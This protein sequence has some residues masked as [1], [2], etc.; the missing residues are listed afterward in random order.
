MLLPLKF[1]HHPDVVYIAQAL[2]GKYLVT[3]LEG[4]YAAGKIVETEAYRAPEDRA[5]HAFNYR[6]TRR[7]EPMYAAGGTAY[8]YL[9]YGL[10]HLFNVVTNEENVPHAV[11]IRA[12]EPTDNLPLMLQRRNMAAL[13]P[14]LTAGPGALSQALGITTQY[15][16]I[17]LYEPAS[18]IRIED[19]GDRIAADQIIA[20]PRVGIGYAAEWVEVPWRFRVRHSSWTSRAK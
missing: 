10:H 20:S 17:H 1:Y 3:E 6:R 4:Q 11:L 12:I 9:C 19:R 13:K 2:L 15:S 8:V 16:G 18:P 5:S 14:A 7:N